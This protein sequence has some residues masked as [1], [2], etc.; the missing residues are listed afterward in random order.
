MTDSA[1]TGR[2]SVAE[3]EN[4]WVRSRIGW[5]AVYLGLLTLVALFTVVRD[6]L[7]V[8]RSSSP[9]LCWL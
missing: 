5:T 4:F 6:D 9:L 8:A 7:T 2:G 1:P 3:L